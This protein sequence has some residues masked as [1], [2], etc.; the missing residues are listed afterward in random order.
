MSM[1][2]AMAEAKRA[3]LLG[4]VLELRCDRNKHV[5]LR[6]AGRRSKLRLTSTKAALLPETSSSTLKSYLLV[7]RAAVC[8]RHSRAPRE[9]N[10][11]SLSF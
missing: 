10:A 8:C 4:A 9:Q 6:N 5:V 1:M 2:I 7:P 11:L 3:K